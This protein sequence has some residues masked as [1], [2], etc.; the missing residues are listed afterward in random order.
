L[1]EKE[2]DKMIDVLNKNLIFEI[3]L[4]DHVK[5]EFGE[6]CQILTPCF[7]KFYHPNSE[8]IRTHSRR[9]FAMFKPIGEGYPVTFYSR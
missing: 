4:C 9:P 7:G 8:E 3:D 6:Y 1:D 2:R 5:D